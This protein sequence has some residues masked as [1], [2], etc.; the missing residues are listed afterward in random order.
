MLKHPCTF[1]EKVKS[2]MNNPIYYFYL[3]AKHF[4][5]FIGIQ[6]NKLIG[7]SVYMTQLWEV[8]KRKFVF[9]EIITMYFTPF[10]TLAITLSIFFTM[11]TKLNLL[12]TH[13]KCMHLLLY[14]ITFP[15]IK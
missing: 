6:I 15:R 13:H 8:P 2:K 5:I 1:C 7:Y 3:A 9:D 14:C 10:F 12:N 11:Q 4:N